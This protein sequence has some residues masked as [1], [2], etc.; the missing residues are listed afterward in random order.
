MDNHTITDMSLVVD[1]DRSGRL[2][3]NIEIFAREIVRDGKE[4]CPRLV[5]FQGGPGF[6]APRPVKPAG[7]INWA[8]DHYRLILLDERGTGSSHPLEASVVLERGDAAAQAD[9]LACFRAD[10][11]VADAEEL[12]REL[13]GDTPWHVLGQSYGGFIN[14]CYLSLSPEGLASVMITAGLP[15]VT[16]HAEETYRRTW[17]KLE[18][19][20]ATLE[21]FPKMNERL[22]DL[23]VH[24]E[25]HEEF[26]PGGERLT[27]RRLRMLGIDLGRS[28]G[29]AHLHFL[30][31]DPYLTVNGERRLKDRFLD[32]VA[33]ALSYRSQPMYGIMHETIYAGTAPGATNW[34][35]H[36][37]RQ[38][39]EQFALPGTPASPYGSERE[40]RDAGA[41]FRLSGEHVFPWQMT[42]DPALAPMAEAAD[43]LAHREDFPSLY[44]PEVLAEN[45]VPTSAWVYW[46][47]MFVPAE[48]SLAT[49]AQIR[50]S[51]PILTNDYQ[52]DGLGVDGPKLLQRMHEQ[53]SRALAAKK[54]AKKAKKAGKAASTAA[55]K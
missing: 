43:I 11:M 54:V 28:T 23:A 22:W 37:M 30:T 20:H 9:F 55:E 40:A 48:L 36:R 15:S 7:W 24:L 35:A 19:R 10:A 46:D 33:A 45:E 12:R 41:P 32:Q 29:P 47:D 42:D 51:Q 8:L 52:H 49:A 18:E 21:P 4:D 17:R 14:T 39:F 50:S 13:Q 26:L 53:N 44:R 3:G 2:P 1:L 5:Y 6:P 25:E 31:E 27:P 34:A 38:E 16:E